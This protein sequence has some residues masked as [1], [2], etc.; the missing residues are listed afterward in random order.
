[1]CDYP[2]RIVRWSGSGGFKNEK[3][4]NQFIDA[5]NTDIIAKFSANITSAEKLTIIIVL[6]Q[7]EPL[8]QKEILK[9]THI[10]NGSRAI[11]FILRAHQC[12]C[13]IV[14]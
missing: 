5:A 13:K 3:E 11:G 4:F 6:I 9:L 14:N 12:V 2:R 8:G 1:M 7:G 10:S